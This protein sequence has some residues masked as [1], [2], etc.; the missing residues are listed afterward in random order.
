MH[1]SVKLSRIVGIMYQLRPFVNTIVMK[2]IYYALF[3]SHVVYVIE[4]WGSGCESTLTKI[5]TLQKR[6]IRLMA[7]TYK[8]YF[9]AL[10]GSL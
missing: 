4:V 7:C 10:P 9:P 8:D 5:I 3:Y 6:V 1:L 2:N